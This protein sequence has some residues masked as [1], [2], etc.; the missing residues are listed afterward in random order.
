LLV[1]KNKTYYNLIN[2]K[3]A[4]LKNFNLHKSLLNVSI[5]KK[6]NSF[7]GNAYNVLDS[8]YKRHSFFFNKNYIYLML[9]Y[10]N[11]K[12]QLQHRK[13]QPLSML[14]LVHKEVRYF[15]IPGTKT[16]KLIWNFEDELYK[17]FLYNN[18]IKDYKFNAINAYYRILIKRLPVFL[19]PCN[20][21]NTL[22]L[23]KIN[24]FLLNIY[25]NQDPLTC[26]IPDNLSIFH[27][28]TDYNLIKK[29]INK[30]AVT[31]FKKIL[32]N[33]K[34]YFDETN[35]YNIRGN[36][37]VIDLDKFLS[38]HKKKKITNKYY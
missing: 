27:I 35:G 28:F 16:I 3:S 8:Y 22:F 19:N 33:Y 34:S 4:I 13:K 11:Y 20:L 10:F 32:I 21:F 6:Y 29:Y 30:N 1:Y 36:Y 15:D 31:L 17:K 14:G 12:K 7:Q 2:T 9:R 18:I 25:R 5:F 26:F 23:F 38:L 24:P 37:C